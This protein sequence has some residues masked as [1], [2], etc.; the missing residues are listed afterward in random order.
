M[1]QPEACRRSHRPIA[2]RM[3]RRDPADRTNWRRRLPQR[4]EGRRAEH[5]AAEH[6]VLLHAQPRCRRVPEDTVVASDRDRADVAAELAP[7]RGVDQIE[8]FGLVGDPPERAGHLEDLAQP[9]RCLLQT[10]GVVPRTGRSFS[11]QDSSPD[12]PSAP[13]SL[14]SIIGRIPSRSRT[15]RN[16]GSGGAGP[17]A[18]TVEA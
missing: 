12:V 6:A 5:P 16:T 3:P 10:P 13:A 4:L 17:A 11:G 7:R 15:P 9:F 8:Q 18:T 1:I 2:H 14:E